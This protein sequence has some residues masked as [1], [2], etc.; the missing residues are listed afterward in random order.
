[1]YSSLYTLQSSTQRL[2]IRA[3]FGFT[4]KQS[5]PI[6]PS[7]QSSLVWWF[8][9]GSPWVA[10]SSLSF[11]SHLS[12]SLLPSSSLSCRRRAGW[13]WW[14]HSRCPPRPPRCFVTIPLVP[15]IIVIVVVII[16]SS[17]LSSSCRRCHHRVIIVII[18]SSLSCHR[19]HHCCVVVVVSLWH[20][21]LASCCHCR[22]CVLWWEV[23]RGG[24]G[25]RDGGHRH[26][27]A[28]WSWWGHC[29][30]RCPPR[31]RPHRPP[32]PPCPP[33]CC[34]GSVFFSFLI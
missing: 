32:H 17:S 5:N 27:R 18:V 4:L 15:L 13:W 1:M 25:G 12:P 22:A 26:R 7:S 14:G 6:L 30:R 20:W 2:P 21:P 24:R 10:S 28:G 23:V 29:H 9:L 19:F 33:R 34:N 11:S 8:V 31:C 3:L 16:V